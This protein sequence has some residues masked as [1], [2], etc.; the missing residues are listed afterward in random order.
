[1]LYRL[2]RWTYLLAKLMVHL[3]YVSLVNLVLGRRVVPELI[4]GDASPER[5]ALEAE[6]ILL[7]EHERDA[8]RAGL[9]ELRGRLG[10]GGASRR[11]ALEVAELLR[12]AEA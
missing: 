3:P 12:G 7:E 5:I 4:Q 9:A 11:A 2:G 1:M 10:S 6:Q 8:M